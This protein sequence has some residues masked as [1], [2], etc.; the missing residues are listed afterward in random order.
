MAGDERTPPERKSHG[1]SPSSARLDRMIAEAVVDARG[2]SEQ[3]VGF[4]TLL[5]DNLVVPF[6]TEISGVEI[7]VERIDMTDYEQIVAVCTHGGSLQRVPI[8]DLPLPDPAP[9]GAEW[10]DAYRLWARGK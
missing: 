6:D 10:I 5:E 8:L 2:E 1:K 3:I 9:A 7:A 4:Y